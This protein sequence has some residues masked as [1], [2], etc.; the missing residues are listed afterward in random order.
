MSAV[1]RS[2]VLAGLIIGLLGGAPGRAAEPDEVARREMVRLVELEVRSLARMTGIETIDPAILA[3]MR[4]VPRHRFVPAPL[5]PYAYRSHPLPVG[6]D[7][8]IAAP[9]LVA[10]MTQL[11]EPAPDDV[12]FE[13]GTGAGYHAAVLAG[14][15]KRVYSV[16][17]AEELTRRAAQTLS[18]L[19]YTNVV[20][21]TGDGYYGWREHGPYDAMVIKESLDHVPS[22]LLAQ[23]KRGGRMVIPL[24]PAGGP[25]FLTLIRRDADGKVSEERI[26]PVRFSPLQGGERL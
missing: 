1:S 25:Q 23:L 10:L 22:P 12:V 8:N 19:G 15:V 21:R 18:D 9:L 4:E 24:G 6:H 20:L 5:Q 14:L 2:M 17:V 11:V 16:E 26:M 13:T 3:R 7:Q